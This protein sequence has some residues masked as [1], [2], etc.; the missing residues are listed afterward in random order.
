MCSTAIE[1]GEP[2]L[3]QY[4][5]HAKRQRFAQPQL[6]PPPQRLLRRYDLSFAA[7][8]L[9]GRMIPSQSRADQASA[10]H[11]RSFCTTTSSSSSSNLA[12]GLCSDASAEQ[13]HDCWKV[14]GSS[15]QGAPSPPSASHSKQQAAMQPA[16][17]LGSLSRS[18]TNSLHHLGESG[19]LHR[20]A[21]TPAG[22]QQWHP[23]TP[24]CSEG[25]ALAPR[26]HDA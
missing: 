25:K 15:H 3:L 7:P 21:D 2:R 6:Q 26:T 19:G 14:N 11:S 17:R 13:S 20:L 16:L 8:A 5:P 4:A 22:A 10:E 24:H 18:S 1:T 23:G 12:A 9:C